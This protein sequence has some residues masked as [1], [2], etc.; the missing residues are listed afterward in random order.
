MSTEA[1]PLIGFGGRKAPIG[2]K[3][4]EK[5]WIYSPPHKALP[6]FSDFDENRSM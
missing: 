3:K 2:L 6:A 1:E 4:E 5:S